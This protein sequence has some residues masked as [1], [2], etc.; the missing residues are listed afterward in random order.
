MSSF[1]QGCLD[2]Q[3]GCRHMHAAGVLPTYPN[4]V[5]VIISELSLNTTAEPVL[6]IMAG[7]IV[8]WSPIAPPDSSISCITHRTKGKIMY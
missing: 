6:N 2:L 4:K 5:P 7:V 1:Q 3:S 8:G